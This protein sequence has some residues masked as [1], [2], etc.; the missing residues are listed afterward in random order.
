[1]EF[2]K[3]SIADKAVFENHLDGKHLGWEYNFFTVF[4]WDMKG[5]RYIGEEDGILIVYDTHNDRC[6]FLP[7]YLKNPTDFGRAVDI[8]EKA[9]P[10]PEGFVRIRGLDS[11]QADILAAR[12]YTVTTSEDDSDYLYLSDD[13]KYL[14]GKKLHAK[15]NFVNR[16]KALYPSHEFC[17]YQDSDFDE[18]L[19]LF[20]RWQAASPH[21]TFDGERTAI[22]RSLKYRTELKLKIGVMKIDGAICGY[23]ISSVNPDGSFQTGFEKADTNYQG[24]YQAINQYAALEFFP[25]GVTVNRQEDMGLE[26]LRRAKQSYRPFAMVDKYKAEKHAK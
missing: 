14:A 16:F 17:E 5:N 24:I 26:G 2:R 20:D 12:G 19:T 23:T 7:P 21:E 22:E 1:M 4:V 10:C 25:D 6:T 18:L 13:L 8:I 15:R 9:C 3:L 11:D